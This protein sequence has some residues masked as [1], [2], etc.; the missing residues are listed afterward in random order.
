MLSVAKDRNWNFVLLETSQGRRATF[1]N[2][3]LFIVDIQFNAYFIRLD[4]DI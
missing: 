1:T 2:G 4:N 3:K